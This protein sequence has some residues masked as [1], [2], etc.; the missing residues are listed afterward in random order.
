MLFTSAAQEFRLYFDFQKPG[1]P[2]Y[3]NR[4]Y[5]ATPI[6]RGTDLGSPGEMPVANLN[7]AS[8]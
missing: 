6:L 8:L 3:R 2:R 7:G 4:R 1:A 5:K